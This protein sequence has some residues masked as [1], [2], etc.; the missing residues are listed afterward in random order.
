MTEENKRINL[1]LLLEEADRAMADARLLFQASSFKGAVSRAYYSAL[2]HARALLLSE[3]IEP[4]SHGG[5]QSM[6]HRTF[7]RAERL[8]PA[9]ARILQQLEGDRL[10]ADYEPASV[11][12]RDMAEEALRNAQVYGETIRALLNSSGYL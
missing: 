7:V 8:D 5:V 3:G 10:E 6:I 9:S 2:N 4:K 1:Q 11:Y 12:T